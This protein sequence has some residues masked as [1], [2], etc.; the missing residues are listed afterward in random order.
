MLK[1][2]RYLFTFLFNI[3]VYVIGRSI[4]QEKK[5]KISRLEKRGKTISI[6]RRLFIYIECPKEY[7]KSI[8]KVINKYRKVK[9]AR[10]I[11]K[12]I[13]LLY[14]G[15]KQFKN[16]IKKTISFTIVPK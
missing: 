14:V 1:W 7:F 16:N 9:D 6:H 3:S 4:R 8:L 2:I 10:S 11:Y 13:V 15:N 5:G 12:I